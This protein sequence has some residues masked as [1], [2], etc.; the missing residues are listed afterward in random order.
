MI[1]FPQQTGKLGYADAGVNIAGQEL[2]PASSRVAQFCNHQAA[3]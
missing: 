2:E 1:L 3:V